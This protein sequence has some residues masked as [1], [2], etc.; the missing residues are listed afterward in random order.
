MSSG[1]SLPNLLPHSVTPSHKQ[2]GLLPYYLT[3]YGLPLLVVLPALASSHVLGFKGYGGEVHCWLATEHGF[4]WAFA[5]PV[6]VVVTVNCLIF[7]LAMR[8]A[9]HARSRNTKRVKD[10]DRE[11]ERERENDRLGRAVTWLKGSASLLSILGLS[12]FTGF[13]YMTQAGRPE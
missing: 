11:K 7:G 4:I 1:P 9:R 12:W 5:G 8:T 13:L 3:G 2:C 6:A 10:R